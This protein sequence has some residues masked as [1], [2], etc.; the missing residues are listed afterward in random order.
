MRE[1]YL[2]DVLEW[3]WNPERG[4][5][6]NAVL[7]VVAAVS[8]HLRWPTP[9][10]DLA[11]YAT[12]VRASADA[13]RRDLSDQDCDRVGVDSLLLLEQIVDGHLMPM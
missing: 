13:A 5:D 4:G 11:Q 10:E 3:G 9:D 6:G 7:R 1:A 8:Q 12:H 2:T